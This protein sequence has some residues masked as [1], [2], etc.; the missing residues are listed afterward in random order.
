MQQFT[1][2]APEIEAQLARA[3]VVPARERELSLVKDRLLRDA[4]VYLAVERE[5]RAPAAFI[6]ALNERESSGSLQTYLGNGQSLHHRTTIVPI[7]RGP[8]P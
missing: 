4:D 3:R 2:L 5:S 8:F 6:M 7:G 1:A